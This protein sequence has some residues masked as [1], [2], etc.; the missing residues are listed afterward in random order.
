MC[1]Y[2]AWEEYESGCAEKWDSGINTREVGVWGGGGVASGWGSGGRGVLFLSKYTEFPPRVTERRQV[3]RKRGGK[4][5]EAS[6]PRKG[7]V[8][9]QQLLMPSCCHSAKC[10]QSNGGH[11]SAADRQYQHVGAAA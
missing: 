5:R 11:L 4:T 9:L 6:R 3:V 10:R 8:R 1:W 2:S 7:R